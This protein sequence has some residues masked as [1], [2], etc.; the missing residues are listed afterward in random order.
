MKRAEIHRRMFDQYGS[1]NST[2]SLSMGRREKQAQ[3]TK[4]DLV[5]HQHCA[6]QVHIGK[7]QVLI[8]EDR[9]DYIVHA[10]AWHSVHL[11]RLYEV[12]GSASDDE[13]G[14]ALQIWIQ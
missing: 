3:P 7:A 1:E 11:E 4:L 5:G 14:E 9:R 2:K 13:L 12:A 8:R 6:E 10:D